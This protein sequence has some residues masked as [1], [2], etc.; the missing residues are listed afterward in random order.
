MVRVD[1]IPVPEP[2]NDPLYPESTFRQD[3]EM[4]ARE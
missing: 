2:G 3:V 4:M 1:N